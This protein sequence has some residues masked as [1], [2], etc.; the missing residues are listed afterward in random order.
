MRISSRAYMDQLGAN[1]ARAGSEVARLGQQIASGK[2]LTRPSDDPLAVGAVVDARSDLA[3]VVNRQKVLNKAS[4]L[5]GVADGALDTMTSLLRR[6]QDIGAGATEP[7]LTSAARAAMAAELRSIRDSLMDEANASVAGDYVFAG[8]LS[9]QPPLSEAGGV[10]SYSGS[11][12]GI[13]LW[14][15]PGRP[16][17]ASVPGDRLLNFE[18]ADGERAVP[19]VDTDIFTLL[20]DLASAVE[21][22]D[23]AEVRRMTPQLQALSENVVEQRG[24]LGAR[25]RRVRDA[26]DAAACAEVHARELLADIE[27]VDLVRA[28][29]DLEAQKLAYQAALAATAKMAQ[30]P[31][32][33]ELEW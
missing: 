6:A 2:R 27:D 24:V 28:I 21:A 14:V 5:M 1:L 7:A 26:T 12:E 33:F 30:L 3:Q 19:D 25:A 10:V 23:D 20:A 22:G 13:E 11:S 18:N 31:T 29:T 8:K 9:R 15:A 16:M 4:R 32:L 17:E